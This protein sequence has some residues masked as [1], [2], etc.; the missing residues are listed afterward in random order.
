MDNNGRS[1]VVSFFCQSH[2]PLLYSILILLVLN[3]IGG[4]P[5][6]TYGTLF[7]SILILQHIATDDAP[8]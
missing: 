3:A 2:Q 4:V 1:I 7:F 8:T 6:R 5:Y